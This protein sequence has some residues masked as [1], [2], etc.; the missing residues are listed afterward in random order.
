MAFKTQDTDEVMVEINMIPFIDVMLVLLIIF[1][2]SVPVIQSAVK[3][4]LP[5]TTAQPLNVQTPHIRLSINAEG[6]YF[7]DALAVSDEQLA[8]RLAQAGTALPPPA[9]YIEAD[10]AVAYE[11]VALA[12]AN[13]QRSGLSQIGFVTQ[14]P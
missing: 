8:S 2:I 3:V 7:W 9:L 12:M 14:A 6:R 1:I 10:K 5:Q 4:D 13:A 11:R